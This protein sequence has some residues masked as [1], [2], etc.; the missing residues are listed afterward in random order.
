MNNSLQEL[1]QEQQFGKSGLKYWFI[2]GFRE[3]TKAEILSVGS[4][5]QEKFHE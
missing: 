5:L 4:V 3:T 1:S 2:I